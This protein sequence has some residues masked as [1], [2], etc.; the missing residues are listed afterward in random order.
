MLY[1]HEL[2]KAYD[3]LETTAILNTLHN[4]EENLA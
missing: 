1:I 3:S 4:S 2:Q